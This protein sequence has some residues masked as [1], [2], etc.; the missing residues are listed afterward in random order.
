MDWEERF[1]VGNDYVDDQHKLII[2]YISRIDELSDRHKAGGTLD[3]GEIKKVM[4][5]L[6]H[7]TV[8]HFRDEEALLRQH[9]YRDLERHMEIHSKLVKQVNHLNGR[10]QELGPQILPVLQEFLN[11]WLKEHILK[12]DMKYSALL[13]KREVPASAKTG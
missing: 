12:V 9:N 1:S 10:M 6:I 2:Q 4:D 3:I 5:Q 11:T 7:Y 8:T 13:G